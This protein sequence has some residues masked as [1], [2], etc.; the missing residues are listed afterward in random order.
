MDLNYMKKNET[1]YEM[2]LFWDKE[3]RIFVVEVP[4][5]S[6]CMAHGSTRNQAIKNAEDA[7]NLWIKTA[8]EDGVE[9]PQPK[10]KLM[11]A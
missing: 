8:R 3:D 7:V 10:G 11:Y 5:L 9:I 2:I 4:E 1:H 6:G